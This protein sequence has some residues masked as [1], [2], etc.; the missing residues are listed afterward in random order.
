[1][2]IAVCE[3][4]L[5]ALSH[6]RRSLPVS[7]RCALLCQGPWAPLPRARRAAGRA[8]GR[9]TLR[10]EP[11]DYLRVLEVNT[12]GPFITTQAFYPLLKKKDTRTIVNVSSELGS[13]KENRAGGTPLSGKIISYTS[14]KA[15]LNMRARP[16]RKGC[17]PDGAWPQA[18]LSMRARSRPTMSRACVTHGAALAP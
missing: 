9:Q 7:D 12:V 4:R 5:S 1:M 16:C 18:A 10:R 17:R 3:S 6:H 11:S 14:S 13:I 8:E 15:A 2:H